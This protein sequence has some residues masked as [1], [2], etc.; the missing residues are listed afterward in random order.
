[1]K[2]AQ[3]SL[4]LLG[5]KLP[6]S[7]IFL[8]LDLHKQCEESRMSISKTSKNVWKGSTSARLRLT[9]GFD[10]LLQTSIW[11][12]LTEMPLNGQHSRFTAYE[13]DGLSHSDFVGLRYA[14]SA[15]DFGSFVH[16]KQKGTQLPEEKVNQQS[17]RLSLTSIAELFLRLNRIKDF[18]HAILAA[19]NLCKNLE[20]D[21]LHAQLLS[22][23]GM[24]F[25]MT[26]KNVSVVGPYIEGSIEALRALPNAGSLSK[27]MVL[28]NAI[29]YSFAIGR[30]KRLDQD[31]MVLR[32]FG[33]EVGDF[34]LLERLTRMDRFMR[35]LGESGVEK[36]DASTTTHDN[37]S[38]SAPASKQIWNYLLLIS[39]ISWESGG[40]ESCTS[41]YVSKNIFPT[42]SLAYSSISNEKRK[43]FAV[44]YH[45]IAA[46]SSMDKGDLKLF[47]GNLSDLRK[48]LKGIGPFDW[49]SLIGLFALV[50]CL[51]A[52]HDHGVF[53][54]RTIR[55][56]VWRTSKKIVRSLKRMSILSHAEHL[57][58]IYKGYIKLLRGKPRDAVD[59]WTYAAAL[60]GMEN[61]VRVR[62]YIESKI[63]SYAPTHPKKSLLSWRSRISHGL[64]SSGGKSGRDG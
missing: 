1:M 50:D 29:Q 55:F 6:R 52:A 49:H 9:D 43:H 33:V 19:L 18:Q 34:Q 2:H 8:A 32:Q 24:S 27:V 63:S 56:H 25:W 17:T 12:H 5:Y 15:R 45:S 46:V 20:N 48:A 4:K 11:K 7:A 31:I 62:K 60:P 64:N 23:A 59:Q 22:A 36:V 41:G 57:R 47:Q 10:N 13:S 26:G 37:A 16:G 14:H 35:I 3:Q 39:A 38:A 44:A 61:F 54:S 53:I 40:K 58:Y 30:W 21:Q 42:L 28:H 51:F